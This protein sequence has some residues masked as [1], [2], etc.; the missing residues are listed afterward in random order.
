SG[1]LEASLRSGLLRSTAR[2]F[3]A[4]RLTELALGEHVVIDVEYVLRVVPALHRP[5]PIPRSS[6]VRGANALRSLVPEEVDIRAVVSTAKRSG[7]AREPRLVYRGLGARTVDRS[8]VD[9][10]PA[11]AV[12]EGRRVGRNLRHG[13]AEDSQLGDGHLRGRLAQQAENLRGGALVH[14]V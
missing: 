14:A 5:E 7:G 2:M 10:H 1:T 13:A 11:R 9:H 8:E 12:R 6:R 4:V 3:S